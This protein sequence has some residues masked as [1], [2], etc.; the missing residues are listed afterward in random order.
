MKPSGHDKNSERPSSINNCPWQQILE[1]VS[2]TTG[3]NHPP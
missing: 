3:E 2:I 1:Y